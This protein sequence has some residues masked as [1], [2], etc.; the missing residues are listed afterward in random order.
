MKTNYIKTKREAGFT[1]IEVL[2]VVLILAMLS[3]MMIMS[4]HGG[5]RVGVANQAVSSAQQNSRI[6]AS[7]L[8]RDIRGIG[9]G[10]FV[11]SYRRMNGGDVGQTSENYLPDQFNYD[12]GAGSLEGCM[13]P[14]IEVLNGTDSESQSYLN[15]LHQTINLT[16]DLRVPHSDIITTYQIDFNFFGGTIDNYEGIGQENFIVSDPVLVARLLK[17]WN[18]LGGNP[19]MVMVVDDEGTYSTMRTITMISEQAGEIRI[20]MEPSQ[21]FNQPTNFKGFLED[22]GHRF[23]GPGGPERLRSM[24]AGDFFVQVSVVSYFLYQHPDPAHGAD[25]WLVRLDLPAAASGSLDI[26]ATDPDTIRP[27]V[28]AEQVADFQVALGIM[29]D[30]NGDGET[31][32]LTWINDETMEQYVHT[33]GGSGSVTDPFRELVNEFREFRFS[34]VFRTDNSAAAEPFGFMRRDN[35]NF[36]SAYPNSE[37]IARAVGV[38]PVIEDHAWTESDLL[39]RLWYHR[40]IQLDR[41]IKVRNLDLGDTYARIS[42]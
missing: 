24:V 8:E 32:Q 21:A 41:L 18:E 39:D 2:I 35:P 33:S 9:T 40:A 29:K 22:M 12:I 34:L 20:K 17:I 25:G 36:G 26:D 10:L 19:I 27:F 31:D 13:V 37:T 23:T 7:L 38:S 42:N 16:N 3:G 11:N 1:L 5:R 4:A 6:A 28:L 15:P 14:P 30:T